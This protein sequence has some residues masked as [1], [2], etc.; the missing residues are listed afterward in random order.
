MGQLNNQNA[1]VS[2]SAVGTEATPF[3]TSLPN[4]PA[5]VVG[6][7]RKGPAFVPMSFSDSKTF[8]KRFG[9]S[10]ISG[11]KTTPVDKFT[12]YAPLAVLEWLTN[13]SAVTFIRVLGVGDGKRRIQDGLNIGDVTNAGFTVGEQ[14]PDHTFL[15]GSLGPN[16]FANVGGVLGRTYFL[17]CFMSESVGSN[18]FSSAGLQGTGSVNGI[19]INTSVPIIRGVLMTPSGVILR[20]SSSGGGINSSAPSSNLIA[21]EGATNGT[22]LGSV[23]LFDNNKQLQ[24][25]VMLLNGHKGSNEYP[26]IITASFDMQSSNYIT[27]VFNLTASLMQQAGHYLKAHWDVYPLTANL[28]GAG[29]VLN[30]AESPTTFE[31]SYS[32]ER[33]V[34]IITSSLFRDVG[35]ATVPNYEAFR[36]RF[37][38]ASTPWIISQKIH[39]KPIN[40]F[41]LH[42]LDSGEN[43]SNLYKIIINNITPPISKESYG[44]FD[45]IIRLI[46][47]F[48]ET[49]DPLE[50]F[51]NLNLD[52]SSN[53]YISKIIGDKHYYFD[54]DRPADNQKLVVD[55]GYSNLS[56]YIRVETSKDVHDRAI[57]KAII[58]VGFRGISHLITSGSSPLAALNNIDKDA[59]LPGKTTILRNTI[60]PPVP[61]ANNISIIDGDQKSPSLTRRWG[62]KLDH[63]TD[64]EKQN[65][66]VVFNRSI[67]SFLSYFPN[68]SV[69][70]INFSV[71]DNSGIA[72]TP[73]LGIIDCDRFCNNLFSLENIK[74]ITG[75]NNTIPYD[76]W[77]LAGYIRNGIITKNEDEKSRSVEVNDFNNNANKSF[78]SF[79]LMMQG[80]F[81]G[82]NIFEKIEYNLSNAAATADMHDINRGRSSAATVSSY[83]SVLKIVN[84]VSALDMQL[85]AIP[86]IRTPIITNQAIDV[87]EN[88]FDAL[89][90]M[91]IEQVNNEDDPIDVSIIQQY[92][93]S[94]LSSTQKT[95]DKFLQ[96]SINSSFVATYYPDVILNAPGENP[97]PVPP[98][99]VV[100]G[101]IALNDSLGHPWFAPAGLT[102]GALKSTIETTVKLLDSDRNL[103]YSNKINP[104]WAPANVGGEK[105]GTVIWGQK[106][107][108]N[109]NSSISRINIRRLLLEIRRKAR[110][111]AMGLLFE[112]GKE[113][114]IIR[115]TSLMSNE[116]VRIQSLFGLQN[117][118]IDIDASSTSV[119]DIENNTIRGKIHV[120]PVKTQEFVSLDFTVSNK[121]SEI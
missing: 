4:S 37:S 75:S 67:D 105:S 103:L 51:I 23:Q 109:I 62:I 24:Q 68:N 65:Q 26:N 41:K 97:I 95:V 2:I 114:V 57:Q 5:V 49:T 34:F 82:V 25:F 43:V 119:V 86:G 10:Y 31:R 16:T 39:G 19:G 106:T 33:S 77:P 56:R 76:N 15:S 28:T 104:I 91:D 3:V 72:D 35:S 112:S 73:A 11:L 80:G 78:L 8:L 108:A 60:T 74:V 46:D 52:P 98:S 69:N 99:V 27:K 93:V 59:L 101:A 110:D 61:M 87:V 85:L 53:S 90:I 70:N 120:Q 84:D 83:L 20:L 115:F 6:T 92:D 116:L 111:I 81:D 9:N 96:R 38:N 54:F 107:L 71:S 121:N 47:D 45:L 32:T 22:T 12:N 18:I 44:T 63:I 58:P 40:L 66:F 50:K 21:N 118:K 64:L 79:Q 42:A 17:G 117:Y 89:Y 29:V 100:L 94:T 55:G 13:S 88:R 102:R 48:E 14:Q 1:G 7:S 30:G 113:S 36:D